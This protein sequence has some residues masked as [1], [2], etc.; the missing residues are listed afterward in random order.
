LPVNLRVESE[1]LLELPG[2]G[3]PGNT[4]TL[5]LPFTG[6]G[7][8]VD[9]AAFTTDLT[10]TRK[11]GTTV[12]LKAPATSGVGPF[13]YW[14]YEPGISMGKGMT[15][16]PLTLLHN[17]TVTAVY[18]GRRHYEPPEKPPID[19]CCK[20]QDRPGKKPKTQHSSVKSGKLDER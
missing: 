18:L 11:E 4:V 10:V 7:V 6:L 13:L 2:S 5:H 17:G 8:N 16:I 9:G 1:A 3:E 15:D 12:K 14:R 19:D 20:R